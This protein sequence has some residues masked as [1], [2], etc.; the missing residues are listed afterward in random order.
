MLIDLKN[1]N[2]LIIKLTL[3][4]NKLSRKLLKGFVV[5]ISPIVAHENFRLPDKKP[6]TTTVKPKLN[7][8]IDMKVFIKFLKNISRNKREASMNGNFH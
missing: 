7:N 4:L 1:A 3:L 6:I 8:E 2:K 5:S